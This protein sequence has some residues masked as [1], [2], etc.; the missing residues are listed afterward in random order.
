[1]FVWMFC[2]F[3]IIITTIT[4]INQDGGVSVEQENV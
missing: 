3:I 4:I 2:E 1:M